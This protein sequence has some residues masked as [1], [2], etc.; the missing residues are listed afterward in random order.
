M[1][2]PPRAGV[3]SRVSDQSLSSEE[4]PV[5]P[6]HMSV[7]RQKKVKF[8]KKKKSLGIADG[9]EVLGCLPN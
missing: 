5:S 7:N 9:A 6:S 1:H 8:V 2:G 3:V 4:F